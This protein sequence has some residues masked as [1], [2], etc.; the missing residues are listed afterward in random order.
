MVVSLA[1]FSKYV[2]T[3]VISSTRKGGTRTDNGSA[4]YSYMI[5]S[6]IFSPSELELPHQN[7]DLTTTK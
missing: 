1:G 2:Y 7:R 3:T 4:T 5:L 6:K